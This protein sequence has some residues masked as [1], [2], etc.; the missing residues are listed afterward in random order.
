MNPVHCC[1]MSRMGI[2][3]RPSLRCR[4]TPVPGKSWSGDSVAKTTIW[5][6]SSG[7]SAA[8]SAR[9][10]AST[11]RSHEPMPV[12]SSLRRR[13]RMPVRSMIHSSVV[14]IHCLRSSFLTTRGGAYAPTPR[15]RDLRIS[16]LLTEPSSDV[17]VSHGKGVLF[18]E[19]AP[20]LDQVAH[21]RREDLI[22]LDAVL[23]L[24]L[25]ER[26]RRRVHRR[27]PQLLRVHLAQTLVPLDGEPLPAHL[28]DR[29]GERLEQLVLLALRAALH[30]ERRRRLLVQLAAEPPQLFVLGGVEELEVDRRLLAPA[31]DARRRVDLDAAVLAIGLDRE[32][33]RREPGM[34]AGQERQDLV[35]EERAH[36]RGI[37][38]VR[39]VELGGLD[40][41]VDDAR[42]AALVEDVEHL[43]VAERLPDEPSELS[44]RQ[45]DAA[46]AGA[47]ALLDR[48]LDENLLQARLVLQ[49]D[50]FLAA[51]HLVQRRLGDVEVAVAD[52]LAVVAEEEREE[53]RAGVRFG[54]VRGSQGE[55]GGVAERV[56]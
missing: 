51:L 17:Q 27:L 37:A 32:L 10:A 4:N 35:V 41:R 55:D 34:A 31:A 3:L 5:I 11:P 42:V 45:R 20:R 46:G 24:H 26:A 25:E 40:Q 43:A 52:D 53:E 9:P 8:A 1:R 14:S 36:P 15:I 28:L 23:D 47:L 19:L 50:L 48:R 12:L 54:G 18:D 6:F 30:H 33:D 56:G 21:E 49:V 2:G 16:G 7:S 39:L 22:R 29:L 44:S 38:Q 13:S